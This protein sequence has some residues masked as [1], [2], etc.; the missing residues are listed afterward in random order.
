[1]VVLAKATLS[2]SSAGKADAIPSWQIPEGLVSYSQVCKLFESGAEKT[3][4]RQ[5]IESIVNDVLTLW[6][7]ISQPNRR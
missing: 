7:N 6:G 3:C 5:L 2:A 4:R 1:M